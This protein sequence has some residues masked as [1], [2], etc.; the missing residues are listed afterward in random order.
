MPLN[1]IDTA[2]RAGPGGRLPTQGIAAQR[3]QYPTPGVC[4]PLPAM[5][6]K[7]R[8]APF[9]PPQNFMPEYRPVLSVRE[10]AARRKCASNRFR[11]VGVRDLIRNAVL[12][13]DLRLSKPANRDFTICP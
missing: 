5:L 7:G 8:G 2:R 9:G 10:P 6:C 12:S 4:I 3:D 1:K 11:A 13:A